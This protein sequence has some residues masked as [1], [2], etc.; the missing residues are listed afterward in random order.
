LQSK[1][2]TFG[3]WKN[4]ND[5]V[6]GK[7]LYTLNDVFLVRRRDLAD[8][9]VTHLLISR[10][11]GAPLHN[12]YDLQNIKA[13]LGWQD[14]WAIEIYPPEHALV[15]LGNVYHLWIFTHNNNPFPFA[16]QKRAVVPNV[17]SMRQLNRDMLSLLEKTNDAV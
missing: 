2:Y 5:V 16:Y 17:R 14:R 11:D 1:L 9:G 4:L 8:P 15:D 10:F 7:M 3:Q 12:W 13:S 6:H